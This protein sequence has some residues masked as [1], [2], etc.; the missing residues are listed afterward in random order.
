MKLAKIGLIIA[1]LMIIAMSVLMH[2]QGALSRTGM[3]IVMAI[4][5]AMSAVLISLP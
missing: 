5:I 3:R 4:T 2:R 1:P